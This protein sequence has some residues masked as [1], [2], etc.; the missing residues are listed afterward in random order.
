MLAVVLLKLFSL[1]GVILHSKIFL[2]VLIKKRQRTLRRI[3]NI[4]STEL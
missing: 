1:L 3:P 2:L 4:V